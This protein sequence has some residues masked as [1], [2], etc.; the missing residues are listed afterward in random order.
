M[1]RIISWNIGGRKAPWSKLATMDADI[2]LLQEAKPPPE[3]LGSRMEID[4]SPWRTAGTGLD[5]PW[6]AAVV[7]LSDRVQVEW[8]EAKSV[9]E[10]G[11]DEF[12]VSRPGTLAAAR[13]TPPDG[14][15]L[16]VASMY[17]PW[18]N[19]YASTGS[20]WIYADGSAH[21]IISDLSR[22]IGHESRHRIIAAGDLNVLYGHGE[23]G[24]EYAAARYE[25]VFARMAAL[26]LPFAGPQ[27]PNGRQ[28]EPWP[29][30]LPRDS[31]NVPT[32]HHNRQT[33][34][35]ATRQ[36]DFVFA[37]ASLHE[38]IRVHAMNGVD[39]WGPSDHCRIA[40]TV[41]RAHDPDEGCPERGSEA[42]GRG[43]GRIGK[44]GSGG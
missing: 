20:R 21:R 34:A 39:Q 19:M 8:I 41:G 26:G 29:D 17:S 27:S 43:S 37:S 25:T 4:P 18:E 11:W 6:K 44:G 30:E 24:D 28:A 23:Y 7:K 36:L 5:R 14:E 3:A 9:P 12:A 15:P 40:V 22:L 10:A 1:I 33:P 38:A 32:Y 35:T 2:A 42:P 16:I 13:V 31:R